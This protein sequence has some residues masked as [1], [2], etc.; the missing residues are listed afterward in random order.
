[1]KKTFTVHVTQKDIN[2]GLP[3]DSGT[4][5]IEVAMTRQ[6]P[7][8]LQVAVGADYGQVDAGFGVRKFLMGVK[9][10]LFVKNADTYK[11]VQ[12]AALHFRW[13]D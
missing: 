10:Q 1:M 11:G 9:A 4:C 7:E 2:K 5:P 8:L 13:S 3:I 6:F 12:P